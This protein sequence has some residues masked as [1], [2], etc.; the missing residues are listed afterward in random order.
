MCNYFLNRLG[1]CIFRP[2]FWH[3]VGFFQ[4]FLLFA[5]YLNIWLSLKN[6]VQAPMQTT[7]RKMQTPNLWYIY[8]QENPC[9]F[10]FFFISCIFE[11][12]FKNTGSNKCQPLFSVDFR[13]RQCNKSRKTRQLYKLWE[14]QVFLHFPYGLYTFK[15]T[16]VS[17]YLNEFLHNTY[18][19]RWRGKYTK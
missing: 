17:K 12:Y 16:N 6:Q 11:F 10:F 13:R 19:D 4:V 1:V 8:V 9:S 14:S 5:I 3:W 2:V 7:G 15:M 18:L